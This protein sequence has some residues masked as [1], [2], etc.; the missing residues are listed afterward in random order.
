MSRYWGTDLPGARPTGAVP[1][2]F[3]HVIAW[4]HKRW[5]RTWDR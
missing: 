5:A 2:P 4:W 3:S 1:P